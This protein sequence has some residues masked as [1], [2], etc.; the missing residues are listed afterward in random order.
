MNQNNIK[1]EFKCGECPKTEPRRP[2]VY[3]Y[4]GPNNTELC[5]KC[6]EKY[7]H[8]CYKC[9]E[10]IYF[11]T[12]G[13]THCSFEETKANPSGGWYVWH[14]D[15]CVPSKAE[16]F[17][18]LPKK[19]LP[20]SLPKL[21][22][23]HQHSIHIPES[24]SPI[25]RNSRTEMHQDAL[26]RYQDNKRFYETRLIEE[27][28]GGQERKVENIKDVIRDY[29]SKIQEEKNWLA[30]NGNQ[31]ERD[32]NHSDLHQENQELRQQLAEVSKQL[33]EVSE[34]LKKM[35]DNAK[36]KNNDKLEQQIVENER[37]IGNGDNVS[38]SEVQKQV[39]KSQA[40]V[41]GFNANVSE[42]D[43]GN[44]SLPYVVGGSIILASLGI[45]GYLVVKKS[46]RK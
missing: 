26:E 2:N 41:N 40:L 42:N 34:E 36:G 13:P 19:E 17:P 44:G 1:S 32:S 24:I 9:G 35:R 25:N 8:D 22:E 10:K 5:C 43:K 18:V 3:A 23:K 15:K 21:V 45:I 11:R 12:G 28:R 37:L 6:G 33:I 7:R 16:Q 31:V 4:R 39:Q 46:R 38:V 20:S 29:E 27:K 30:K 14:C